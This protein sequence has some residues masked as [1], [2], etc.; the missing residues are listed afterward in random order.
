M[1]KRLVSGMLASVAVLAVAGPA[2]SQTRFGMVGIAR[3]Q[4]AVINA[5]MANPPDDGHPGCRLVL[6]FVGADGRTLV[7][8]S[9]TEIKKLVTLRGSTAERLAFRAADVIPENQLRL[10]IRAVLA[11]PPDDGTPSACTG[12]VATLELVAPNGWTTLSQGLP[13]CDDTDADPSNDCL[14]ALNN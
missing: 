9:H 10:P 4:G 14:G 5:V 7:N 13:P 1:S 12:M 8:S 11:S 6:T 3:D 2:W